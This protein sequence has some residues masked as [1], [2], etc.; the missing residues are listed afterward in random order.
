[1]AKAKKIPSTQDH[2]DIEDIRDD[3]LILKNAGAAAVLQTTAVNF[4]LL[5]EGEQ[6][7]MIFAYASLLNSLTFPIQVI[8]RSKRMDISNYLKLLETAK[9]S[10]NNERLAH[11]IDLYYR[12]IRDLVSRNEVLDKR[13]YL[14]VP[15]FAGALSQVKPPGLFPKQAPLVNK[16]TTLEK[17]K[18]NLAPKIAHLMKQIG[19]IGVRAKQLS[20]QELVELFYDLYNPEVAREQKAALSTQDYTTPIVEPALQPTLGADSQQK[21]KQ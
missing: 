20:T 7:S 16:W 11:Q 12:F 15:Y 4:D 6:D 21:A 3:L 17:A 14:V 2:L 8:V 5:S 19:R 13:F 18:I 9:A 1:M 10:T